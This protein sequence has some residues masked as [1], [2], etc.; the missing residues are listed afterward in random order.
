MPGG[1]SELRR[2]VFRALQGPSLFKVSRSQLLRGS[3]SYR[4]PGCHGVGEDSE[5]VPASPL[6]LRHSKHSLFP[7][8][9][10]EHAKGTLPRL[11]SRSLVPGREGQ[12]SPLQQ[13][14]RWKQGSHRLTVGALVS[15][16]PGLE[17]PVV[18]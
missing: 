12:A 4:K 8:N 15:G 11:G 14:R 17:S 10:R 5:R 2:L 16:G 1:L 13:R 7:H 9:P 18:P 6:Q 3:L